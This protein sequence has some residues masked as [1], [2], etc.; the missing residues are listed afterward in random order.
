MVG[1]NAL[2][3]YKG[4]A[5]GALFCD[6]RT[7]KGPVEFVVGSGSLLPDIE[8]TVSDMTVGETTSV[9]IPAE[10]AYGIDDEALI[11]VVAESEL[12]NADALPV[13]EYVV[14]ETA[15]ARIRVK[16]LKKENGFVYLDHNHELAGKDLRFDITLV[17]IKVDSAIEREL[18][19]AGCACGCDKLKES[20][21]R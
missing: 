14:F 10:R 6:T 1:D 13:G 18:H 19:P 5:D 20:L 9:E 16:V 21:A 15:A 4:Y 8:K 3:H 12:P 17:D 11:E 7:G 2:I